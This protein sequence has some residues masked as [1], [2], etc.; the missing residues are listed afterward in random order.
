MVLLN[1]NSNVIPQKMEDAFN[2]MIFSLAR[3]EVDRE[4]IEKFMVMARRNFGLAVEPQS[5]TR[6]KV[7]FANSIKELENDPSLD[8]SGKTDGPRKP[9]RPPTRNLAS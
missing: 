2:M 8:G 3:A 5:N 9:G 6:L 4:A 1:G 7:D